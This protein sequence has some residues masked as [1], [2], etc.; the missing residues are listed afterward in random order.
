MRVLWLVKVDVGR[1]H[2][3]LGREQELESDG[4]SSCL[5]LDGQFASEHD[6]VVLLLTRET[7]GNHRGLHRVVLSQ[8][9]VKI[10]PEF[11]GELVIRALAQQGHLLVVIHFYYYNTNHFAD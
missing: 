11:V 6:D 8:K 7:D 4:P 9:V 3:V 1:D 10:H 2:G 5:E